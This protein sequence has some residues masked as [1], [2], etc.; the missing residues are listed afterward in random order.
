AHHF[1]FGK[2][3]STANDDVKRVALEATW[4]Q[5]YS[6]EFKS[7]L[8]VQL[9]T[10]SLHS[11]C[12][13]DFLAFCLS[14]GALESSGR[15]VALSFKIIMQVGL[16][17][18]E[19]QL[20]YLRPLDGPVP[21]VPMVK[22]KRRAPAVEAVSGEEVTDARL[23]CLALWKECFHLLQPADGRTLCVFSDGGEVAGAKIDVY[24]AYSPQQ[25]RVMALP[26]Q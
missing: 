26:C 14:H 12:L 2:V 17:L 6:G 18:D 3:F 19:H 20:R 15:L 10:T 4:E 5:L 21:V 23:Q 7:E 24:V 25:N 22:R 11:A 8:G 16:H 13:G 1:N 9:K